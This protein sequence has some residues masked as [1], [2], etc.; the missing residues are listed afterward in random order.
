MK[1]LLLAIMGPTATGKTDLSL[2]LAKQF[3]GELVACD[4]RQVYQGLDIGT[5]KHPGGDWSLP[6]GA[7]FKR[8]DLRWEV[9][10]INIWMYDV[11]DPKTQYTVKD[12]VAQS[13]SV[14]EDIISRDK[15]PILVGGTGLYFKA[16]LEGL[17]N[18]SVPID[19]DL[20]S[21]LE[22]LNLEE[23]QSE[24]KELDPKKWESLNNS[25]KNNPRRLLR[26]IELNIMNP[27]IEDSEKWEALSE[28]YEVLKIGLTAPRPV[29]N[30]KIDSRL[31]SHLS[32]GLVEEG[33]RL[34]KQG[35]T[36]KRLKSLGLEYGVLADLFE[37]KISKDELAEK[38]K[39]KLHQYAKRQLIWFKKEKNIE[40]FDVAT[41]GWQVSLET[42]V[43]SWYYS[44][45]EPQS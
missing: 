15:L 37:G 42:K 36:L 38:L 33:E 16:L 41:D 44:G 27:Y 24:L 31:D 39:I 23:L 17:P 25:E 45:D 3:N 29:L 34:L 6:S 40:W 30:I 8:Y 18:L 21:K 22:E 35:L 43:Q 5:V 26:S 28:K 12:Y 4:S 10:G 19:P 9:S 1:M 13:T 7:G 11:V 20:R 2:R 32:E 14:I